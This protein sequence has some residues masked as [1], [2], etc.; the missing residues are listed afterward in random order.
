MILKSYLNI[1]SPAQGA[2]VQR[3]KDKVLHLEARVKGLEVSPAADITV[4]GEAP[5]G[6]ALAYHRKTRSVVIT[7][8]DGVLIDLEV[9][10][11]FWPEDRV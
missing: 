7:R 6:W 8:P 9:F 10:P 11:P 1:P 2:E 5:A 4:L 3:L